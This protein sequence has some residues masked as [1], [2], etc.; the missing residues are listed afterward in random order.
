MSSFSKI[1][2]TENLITNILRSRIHDPELTPGVQA[3]LSLLYLN[4]SANQSDLC[5]FTSLKPAAMSMLLKKMEQSGF[6][7]REVDSI[8]KRSHIVTLTSK[9]YKCAELI[10]SLCHDIEGV[11]L[12]DF[13]SSEAKSLEEL[14]DK[15]YQNLDYISV[16]ENHA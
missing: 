6:I 15:V 2:L 13:T 7:E 4:G 14:L 12:N 3:I 11:V 9:G 1:Y 5:R 8:D 16:P 10:N